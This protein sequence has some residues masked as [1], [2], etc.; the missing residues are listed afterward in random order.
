MISLSEK[1][2][3]SGPQQDVRMLVTVSFD[4]LPASISPSMRTI[5]IMEL[6]NAIARIVEQGVNLK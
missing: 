6:Q 1:V 5:V 4:T 3:V 2:A